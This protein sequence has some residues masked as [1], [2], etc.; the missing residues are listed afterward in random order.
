MRKTKKQKDNYIYAYYQGITNGTFLV[1]KF[2]ARVYEYLIKGLEE[3][4]FFYD[5]VK[6]KSQFA[7][8]RCIESYTI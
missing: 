1:N 4:Q 8:G 2:I 7:V 6:D 5:A 3:K